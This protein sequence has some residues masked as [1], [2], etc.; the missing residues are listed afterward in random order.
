[1]N[2]KMAKKKYIYIIPA[3]LLLSI[4]LVLSFNILS[5]IFPN[6]NNQELV[7]NSQVCISKNNEL[8]E[9]NSNVLTTNG[10]NLIK[11]VLGSGTSSSAIDYI[12]L[13]NATA[14]C[15]SASAS[16]TTLENEYAGGGLERAQ[17]DYSSNGDGNWT[18]SET[19]TATAD[20]LLTNKT[21]IF[22]ATSGG[23]LFAENTFTLVTLQTN[24]LLT[25]NWTI[26]VT[27]A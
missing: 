14:G 13:C 5:P 4:F 23:T 11:L 20:N 3:L 16:S 24:D 17:G 27:N 25:I 6:S 8:I 2:K 26:W 19:F 15:G 21:G 10:S 12:A 18:I 7:Y 22:N 1:M 9:C